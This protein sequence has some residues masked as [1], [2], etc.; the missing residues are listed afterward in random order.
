MTIDCLNVVGNVASMSGVLSKV[1][2]VAASIG[3]APGQQIWFRVIDNKGTDSPDQITFV[4]INVPAGSPGFPVCTD[5]D[6]TVIADLGPF[7]LNAIQGGNVTV[8]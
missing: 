3:F 5:S 6:A 7:T 8:H 2:A 1:N 4:F